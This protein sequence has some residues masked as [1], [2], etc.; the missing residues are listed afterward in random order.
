[1]QEI[2]HHLW[3]DREAREAA[4]FYTR[5]FEASKIK[6]TTTLHDTPSGSVD[7]VAL[8]LWGQE[9]R[10]ISA[11]PLFKFNPSVSFLVASNS[12]EEVDVLWER[13]SKGGSTLMELGQYPWSE[14]YGWTRDKFGLSWQLMYTGESG[15]N[16]RIAPKLMYVG[17]QCGR[18]EEAISL[19]TSVFHGAKAGPFLRYGRGEEPDKEGTI[20]HAAFTLEGQEFAAMDSAYPHDF[21]FN[22]AISFMVLCDNQQEIDDYW[23]KLSADPKAEQ[24]GWIKDKFGLSWQIVPAVMDEMLRNKDK[25]ALA[26]VTQ[27]FLKMKKFDIEALKRAYEGK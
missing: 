18:A 25:K 2:A 7:L 10:F 9:F 21:A 16:R 15:I 8:D 4:E 6:N 23:E 27:A 24:C 17:S 22:E 3:F 13:L 12:V 19:Y 14:K 11:G 20:K 26:R 5:T 1:M